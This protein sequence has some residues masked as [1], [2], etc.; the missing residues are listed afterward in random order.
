MSNDS[1]ISPEQLEWIQ[2]RELLDKK[3]AAT[4]QLPGEGWRKIVT[5]CKENPFVPIGTLATVAAISVGLYAMVTGR[6]R[7][8]QLMMRCRVGAQGFAITA[9]LVGFEIK[10]RSLLAE[11]AE[12]ENQQSSEQERS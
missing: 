9:I 2:L 5:K 12:K 3:R 8:S 10:R 1:N 7:L 11:K 4:E 6:K